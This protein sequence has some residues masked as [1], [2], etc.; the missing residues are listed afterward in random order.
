[1][2]KFRPTFTD[3]LST[4]IVSHPNL[5]V[6]SPSAHLCEERQPQEEA[7]HGNG[8]DQQLPAARPAQLLR[9]QVD[10][11]RG[12]GV[13]VDE[14]GRQTSKV[15]T[16]DQTAKFRLPQKARRWIERT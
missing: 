15:N 5:R 4:F 14:L 3:S 16:S 7:D 1:M 6:P 8:Q 11:D 10:D 12:Q 9:E 13:G 2:F